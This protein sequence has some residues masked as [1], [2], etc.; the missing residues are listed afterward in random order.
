MEKDLKKV[1]LD[2]IQTFFNKNYELSD[3]ADVVEIVEDW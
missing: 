1:A 2:F 3:I